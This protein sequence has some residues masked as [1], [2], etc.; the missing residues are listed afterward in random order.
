MVASPVLES[1][2]KPMLCCPCATPLTFN[3]TTFSPEFYNTLINIEGDANLGNPF[4]H[5]TKDTV[6][7]TQIGS[8]GRATYSQPF[9]LGE[10]TTGQL[11][12]FTA[13]FTFII[14]SQHNATYTDGLAFFL[15][16]SM[17]FLNSS[18]ATGCSLGLP[19]N[20]TRQNITV[21]KSQYPF[22][23]VEF[24]SH[25]NLYLPVVDPHFNHVGINVNSIKSN[26]IER[27][28]GSIED[29]RTNSVWISYNSSTKNLT[30]DFTS[31]ANDIQ[32]LRHSIWFILWKLGKW[33]S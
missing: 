19:V 16:P 14:Y 27:W 30:V 26:A 4:L 25:S 6:G 17:T 32:V 31:Y 11:A 20:G 9:L 3:F 7:E 12:E 1:K 22:V 24:D 8:V 33:R 18:I 13:N 15:A 21:P 23:A 29:G 5:L 10:T 28:N 2:P